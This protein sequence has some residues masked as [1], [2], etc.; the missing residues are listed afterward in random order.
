M[1]YKVDV[2]KS[3]VQFT[4]KHLKITTVRGRFTSFD[5]TLHVNEADPPASQV[6]GVVKTG[7]VRTG[8]GP[9]DSSLRAKSIFDS[10]RCP[11]MSFRSTRVGP[12]RG[13]SFKVYG[14]LT[15]KDITRPVVWDVVN[16]GE[17]PSSG[18]KRRWA[19]EATTELRR[20]E[21]GLRF[22]PLMEIAGLLV[23]DQ[24][25]AVCDMQFVEE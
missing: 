2:G 9:R 22:F 6:E 17:Q 25:K 23:S 18:G 5:G 15:I 12:I 11:D 7:T 24:V 3:K 20:K 8:I 14:D 1:P 19:F 13:N 4:V 21:F 16:K 10:K